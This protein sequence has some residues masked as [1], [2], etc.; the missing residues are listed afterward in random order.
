MKL[1]PIVKWAG[2]K[3]QLLP[4]IQKRIPSFVTYYEP[5]LGGG[6]VLFALLPPRAVVN[7]QNRE[8]INLYK[9]VKEQLSQL[10]CELADYENNPEFYYWIRALDRDPAAFAKLT[11]VERAA[12]TLYLNKTCFNGLYRVNSR[13]E[14]NTPFGF[15]KNPKFKD[16]AALGP[17]SVYLQNAEIQLLSTDFEEAL[18]TATSGDFVYLDPPYDP[19]SATSNFTSYSKAGFGREEQLRLQKVCQELHGRGVK[20]LL[21]NSATDFIQELYQEFTMEIVPARR[22]INAQGKG[23]GTVSEVLVRNY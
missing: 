12:R 21:S 4:Q 10:L 15:Y 22:A 8:L 17:V 3:S 9:V 6:A 14:F 2:G 18:A 11:D 13:G 7:D 19:L 5:F 23:R 1:Q 16:E 20:F